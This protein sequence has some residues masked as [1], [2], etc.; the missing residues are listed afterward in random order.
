[1]QTIETK[2]LSR[3]SKKPHETALSQAAEELA[4]YISRRWPNTVQPPYPDVSNEPGAG[5]LEDNFEAIRDEVLER[6]GERPDEFRPNFTPYAYKEQ[7]WRTVNLYSYFL[8][9]RT[10][11][12][13]FPI[14]DSV[15]RQIP[16]MSMA[17]IAVLNPRTQVKAHF[18]DTNGILRMHMGL[19][20]PGTLPDLGIRMLREDRCWEEGKVFAISISQRHFAW[21]DTDHHRIVLVVDRVRPEYHRRRFEVASNALA[22]IAMKFVATQFPSLKDLPT[23]LTTATRK[24]IGLAFRARIAAQRRGD[25]PNER[26]H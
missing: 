1:L 25:L 6:F 24:A 13:R 11:C 8:R 17:Q 4:F 20:V 7:G 3:S 23:P 10:N 21:N 18:G 16:D 5:L 14:T 2:E 15:V 22:V 12:E 26:K 19:V 9:D